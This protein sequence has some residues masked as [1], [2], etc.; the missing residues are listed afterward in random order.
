[1]NVRRRIEKLKSAAAARGAGI[2]PGVWVVIPANGRDE[3]PDPD[4]PVLNGPVVVVPRHWTP[5][6][7]D[8]YLARLSRSRPDK[9]VFG[10]DYDKL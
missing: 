9:V 8:A 4:E 5:D 6:R 2:G 10:V 3:H 1:V 7:T